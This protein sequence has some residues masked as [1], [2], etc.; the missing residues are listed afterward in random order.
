MIQRTSLNFFYEDDDKDLK[1]I[2]NIV[3]QS[4]L[5]DLLFLNS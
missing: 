5:E 3:L 1:T 4:I 2:E